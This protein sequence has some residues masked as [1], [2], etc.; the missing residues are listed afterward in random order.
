MAADDQAS[1]TREPSDQPCMACRGTGEVISMLGGEPSTL[2]CPWCEG[3]GKRI[4]GHD[5]QAH[6]AKE[7]AS[8]GE[9]A[10]GEAAGDGGPPPDDEP[11]TAA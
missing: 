5:A 8:G 9:A 3:T 10:Q 6:W 1:E 11:P 4:P 2:P 7:P